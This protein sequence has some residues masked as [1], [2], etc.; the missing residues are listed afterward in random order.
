MS[1]SSTVMCAARTVIG[2]ASLLAIAALCATAASATPGDSLPLKQVARIL[3]SGPPVRFDYESFDPSTGWL[4]I[5]HMDADQLLAF[6]TKRLRIV[7]TI[8]ARVCTA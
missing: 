7:K 6:D 8:A 3:L 4:W 2:L 1:P 5:S